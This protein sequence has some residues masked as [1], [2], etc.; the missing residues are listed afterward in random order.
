MRNVKAPF[1][2]TLSQQTER[3]IEIPFE[4]YL[5]SHE[6]DLPQM[7]KKLSQNWDEDF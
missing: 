5:A 6:N 4:E 7:E 1:I 2:P 3:V